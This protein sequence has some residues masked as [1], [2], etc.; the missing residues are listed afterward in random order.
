MQYFE[1]TNNL[2]AKKTYLVKESL[3]G[4]GTLSL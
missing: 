3:D 2:C 1:T 4:T